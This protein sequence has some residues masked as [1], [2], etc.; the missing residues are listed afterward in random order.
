MYHQKYDKPISMYLSRQTNINFPQKF[1][2]VRK[3][4]EN[5]GAT[6]LFFAE[7]Q[8]KTILNFSLD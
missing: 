8:Q 6:M 2:F 1:T 5:D 7:K 4:E 3:L